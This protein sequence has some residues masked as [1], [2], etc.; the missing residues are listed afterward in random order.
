MD[1]DLNERIFKYKDEN[2][3]AFIVGYTGETGKELVKDLGRRQVFKKV[4]LLGRRTVDLG[5]DVGPEFEQR[6][7]DFEDV[8][9]TSDVF[10]E[11]D[12]GFCTLGTT[13]GKAGKDGFVKVDK[14]YTLN[15]ARIAKENGCK[16]FSYCSSNGA[17]AKSWFLYMRIK[18]EVEEALKGMNFNRLSIHRPGMLMCD[19]QESRF[20]EKVAR[21]IMKPIAA[22]FP[23]AGSIPTSVLARGMINDVI[24]TVTDDVK[25]FENRNIHVVA[26]NVKSE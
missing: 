5:K 19:R 17:N 3:T 12:V 25:T 13:R 23:T 20:G 9:K 14:G 18:G 26:G 1:E 22:L 24:S 6:I 21:G 11:A 8:E 7:I 10:A 16:H 4:Y 2:H 15:V